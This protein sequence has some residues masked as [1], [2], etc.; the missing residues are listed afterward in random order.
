MEALSSVLAL[1]EA[2]AF[3]PGEFHAL[4]MDGF[5]TLFKYGMAATERGELEKG[6]IV[7][8]YFKRLLP[9]V[10]E[11]YTNLAVTQT[12]MGRAEDAKTTLRQARRKFPDNKAA[13]HSLLNILQSEAQQFYAEGKLKPAIERYKEI[14]KLAPDDVLID[15]ALNLGQLHEGMGAFDEAKLCFQRALDKS[16]NSPKANNYMC[17]CIMAEVGTVHDDVGAY[18]QKIR[19]WPP[20]R[21]LSRFFVLQ[22]SCTAGYLLCARPSHLETTFL[23]RL[24]PLTPPSLSLSPLS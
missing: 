24:L 15:A 9:D 5:G 10:I 16:P 2:K 18:E 23:S 11:G 1:P 4:M 17:K 8:S 6:F 19:S 7:F 20:K 13:L 3:A 22:I 12:R 21:H 14:V